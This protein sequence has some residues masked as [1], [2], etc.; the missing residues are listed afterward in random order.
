MSNITMIFGSSHDERTRLISTLLGGYREQFDN[1]VVMSPDQS[2][3]YNSFAGIDMLV[4]QFDQTIIEDILN[5]GHSA[6]LLILDDCLD[7]MDL[8]SQIFRRLLIEA[9]HYNITCIITNE[10]TKMPPELRM[11]CD[12]MIFIG[13]Q[14]HQTMKEIYQEFRWASFDAVKMNMVNGGVI[15][16][17]NCADG[18]I[19][20]IR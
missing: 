1:I 6:K 19:I 10:Y 3:I 2:N 18:E 14:T 9:R 20:K 17:R 7:H 11:Q 12:N 5:S 13:R 16:I 8:K 15:L 4:P